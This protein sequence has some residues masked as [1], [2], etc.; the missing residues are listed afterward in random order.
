MALWLALAQ[1]AATPLPAEPVILYPD[2]IVSAPPP[3]QA[4]TQLDAL[5]ADGRQYAQRFDMPLMQAVMELELQEASVPLTDRLAATWRDRLAGILI[6]HKPKWRIIV[7]LT[8]DTPVPSQQVK[9]AGVP[10]TVDFRTGAPA[11]RDQLLA[12]IEAYGDQ[13]RAAVKHPPGIGVDARKGML[14]IML[15]AED[16]D[17][18]SETATARRLAAIAHVPVRVQTWA[19]SDKD[20]GVEGGGRVVGAGPG[21]KRKYLCTTGFAVTDGTRTGITTAA[22]CPDELSYVDRDRHDQPL[23]LVGA[24]GARYQDVQIHA[25]SI[26]LAPLIRADDGNLPRPITSWRNRTSTRVGDFVC[27]R[28]ERTGYSC[29]VVQYV[30]YAPP[31]TL[32]AGVCPA[33][34]VAV[35]GPKCKSGDS[36]GPIFLGTIAFGTTKAASYT[37]DGTCKLYYYMSTDYL[38][39]GWRLLHE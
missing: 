6:D 27:H 11:T 26:P 2:M 19:E 13:I 5:L 35:K 17:G 34:W 15:R 31:R 36:G 32:C 10:V 24:W 33:L 30:D 9:V 3:I 12:A 1:A 18:S 7:V 22:H 29:S 8:G 4:E 38:P 28:G 16:L 25:A 23:T 20:L 21:E 37:A 14:A 39:P